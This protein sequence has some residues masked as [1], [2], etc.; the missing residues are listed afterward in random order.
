MF[1]CHSAS[2]REMI[3]A[4]LSGWAAI[5]TVNPDG[6]AGPPLKA[7]HR[8][9][10]A[11]VELCRQ[12]LDFGTDHPGS[13]N[14]PHLVVTISED[15]LRTGLGAVRLPDGGIIPA[16][17]LR[18]MA[19]DAKIIPL[20]LNSKSMP[21]D[22]GRESRTVTPSQRIALNERDRGC[23]T[24]GCDRPPAACEAHHVWHWID[25]GPTNLN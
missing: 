7:S 12:A 16:T 5:P 15:K 4:S 25:G 2:R 22:V 8:R 13:S 10:L 17:D 23:K 24:P 18:R 14:K 3:L 21:L 19:C 1:C 11:L 6:T 20:L 9:A